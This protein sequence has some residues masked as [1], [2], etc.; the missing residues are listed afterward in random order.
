ML[1]DVKPLVSC[2]N[3][4]P[5]I[6]EEELIW[7]MTFDCFDGRW[8]A[9]Q[10]V[11]GSRVG[12]MPNFP[13]LGDPEF[14]NE[15]GP[16]KTGEAISTGSDGGKGGRG[17]DDQDGSSIFLSGLD[18]SMLLI[19]LVGGSIL[20]GLFIGIVAAICM[21]SK[22]THLQLASANNDKAPAS[23]EQS[24]T[25]NRGQAPTPPKGRNDEK[26]S[27]RAAALTTVDV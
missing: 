2:T 3:C 5:C 4:S 14:I 25:H 22:K 23:P 26:T 7:G 27:T 21:N 17:G 20:V 16:K 18:P 24:I 6:D 1:Q 10:C 11:T 8:K 15:A 9:E 12:H 13:E 19:L